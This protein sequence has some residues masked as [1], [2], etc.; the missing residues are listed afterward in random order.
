MTVTCSDNKGKQVLC[1]ADIEAQGCV[2]FIP[3]ATPVWGAS[4][5]PTSCARSADVTPMSHNAHIL[6]SQHS[7]SLPPRHMT[8]P[9]FPSTTPTLRGSTVR[10]LTLLRLSLRIQAAYASNPATFWVTHR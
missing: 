4:A 6:H 5:S 10:V 1:M 8:K 7:W 2:Q 3:H 9:S